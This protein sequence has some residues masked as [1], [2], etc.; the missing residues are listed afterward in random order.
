MSDYDKALNSAIDE[1]HPNIIH[2]LCHWHLKQN[3]AKNL[4]W[5]NTKN[6]KLKNF[7]HEDRKSLYR[8]IYNLIDC[9][10]KEKFEKECE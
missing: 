5:L 3:I 8:K 9:D 7:T 6:A 4:G 1:D 2:I 10:S